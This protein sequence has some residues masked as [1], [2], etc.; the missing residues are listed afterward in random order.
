MSIRPAAFRR[1]STSRTEI[2]SFAPGSYAA[3]A[4]S[5]GTPAAHTAVIVCFRKSRRASGSPVILSSYNVCLTATPSFVGIVD[6]RHH[7]INVI[8]E[9]VGD[10]RRVGGRSAGAN[11]TP[12][13][14][15]HLDQHG[16]L[17]VRELGGPVRVQEYVV[18]RD[19]RTG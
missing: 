17:G 4:G 19:A 18:P 6:L 12:V 13:H 3:R 1:N 9:A 14:Q 7:K 15:R 8:L 10:G 16:A 11:A 2:S 5:H